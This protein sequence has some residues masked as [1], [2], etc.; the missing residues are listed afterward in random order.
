MISVI[1]NK[2]GCHFHSILLLGIKNVESIAKTS[3][4]RYR[5]YMVEDF[6]RLKDYDFDSLKKFSTELQAM[7]VEAE[8]ARIELE[9]NY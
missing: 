8:K 3:K 6:A 1:R 7:L 2:L 5:A 4:I 9:S